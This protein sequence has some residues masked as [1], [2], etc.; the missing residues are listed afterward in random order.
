MNRYQGVEI[1]NDQYGHR[2]YRDVK[3]PDIPLSSD[4][5]YIMTDFTDRLDLIARDYYNDV[6]LWWVVAVANAEF[7]SAD[8][9]YVPAATQLRIPTDVGS[10]IQAYN[11]LNNIT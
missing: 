10:I 11:D 9:L 3:Y 8:S 1:I 4:D 7:I 5:I 6:T 2:Y